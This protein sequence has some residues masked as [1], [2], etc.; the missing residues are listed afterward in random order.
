MN[1]AVSPG[2]HRLVAQVARAHRLAH[3]VGS[4][5]HDVARVFHEAQRHQLLDDRAVAC[6]VGHAQSKSASGLEAHRCGRPAAA[7]PD[8]AG[9][10]SAASQPNSCATQRAC[11]GW[12]MTSAPARRA[13]RA[14][15]ARRLGSRRALLVCL[16]GRPVSP[17]QSW[18]PSSLL[19]I[20]VI[21]A[22]VVLR[23]VVGSQVVGAHRCVAAY[24]VLGQHQCHRR[25]LCLRPRGLAPAPVARRWG[26]A[27]HW[28]QRLGD[29]GLQHPRRRS[30]RA[31]R[32]S[33]E[34]WLSR[35]LSPR[36]RRRA[37]GTRRWRVRPG[38]AG[39]RRGAPGRRACD[40]T[41][42]LDV[43]GLLDLLTAVP[44]ARVAWPVLDAPSRRRTRCSSA[45]TA[46]ACRR[47]WVC[48]TE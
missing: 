21:V 16:H 28:L 7:A 48:G 4:D 39:R 37:A 32:V 12:P 5:Q 6:C 13:G 31:G 43:G 42:A 38:P 40:A 30:A 23:S 41:R 29:G 8:C 34:P 3:P 35:R 25:R 19:P 1:S 27:R 33:A 44:A 9:C 45:S 2:Q 11:S 24:D 26:A 18:G 10:R 14:G 20:V 46:Q 22:I 47:T 17:R 36:A 15:A